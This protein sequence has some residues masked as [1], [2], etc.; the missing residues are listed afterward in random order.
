MPELVRLNEKSQRSSPYINFITAL[1]N[2]RSD[3]ALALLNTISAQFK[4]LMKAEGLVVNRFSEVEYNGEFAGRNFNAGEL[5]EIVLVRKDGYFYPY[6]W[7]LA[8]MAHEV[9]SRN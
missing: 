5:I 6:S 9:S 4:S 1:P 8:V 2:K 3:E 7:L